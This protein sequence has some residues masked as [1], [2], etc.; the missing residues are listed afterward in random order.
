MYRYIFCPSIF[1][2][3]LTEDEGQKMLGKETAL[4]MALRQYFFDHV[5]VD[6]G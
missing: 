3:K 1:C 5:A 2:R 6:V 4:R